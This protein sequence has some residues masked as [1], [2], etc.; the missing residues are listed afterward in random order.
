M[1]NNTPIVKHQ[2]RHHTGVGDEPVLIA[3]LSEKETVIHTL[4]KTLYKGQSQKH[5]EHKLSNSEV[6]TAC[7]QLM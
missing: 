6:T 7:V 1:F 2:T 4:L 5:Q 3:V